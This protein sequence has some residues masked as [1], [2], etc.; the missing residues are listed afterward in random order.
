MTAPSWESVFRFRIETGRAD[1][2]A[3]GGSSTD[4]F[5][6]IEGLAGGT[7]GAAIVAVSG[8]RAAGGI[9]IF[10]ERRGDSH[11]SSDEGGFPLVLDRDRGEM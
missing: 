9:V 2:V 7:S 1:P 6:N 11:P 5:F 4:F 10:L 8:T 3:D